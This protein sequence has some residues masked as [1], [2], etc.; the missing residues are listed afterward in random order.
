VSTVPTA[1]ALESEALMDAY[2]VELEAHGDRGWQ[3]IGRLC[4]YFKRQGDGGGLPD[5]V[6]IFP[7]SA[8]WPAILRDGGLLRLGLSVRFLDETD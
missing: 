7:A 5:G 1:A 2:E 4:R 3:A 8:V 6:T